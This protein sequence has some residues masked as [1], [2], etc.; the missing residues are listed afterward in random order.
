MSVIRESFGFMPDKT[1]IFKYILENSSGTQAHI[2]TLGATLQSFIIAD[3]NGEMKDVL[4][5]FDSV[6]DYLEKSNYQGATVGRYANRIG[7][8]SIDINGKNY[9]L[10]ANEKNVTSL[11]SAGDFSYS[12]W[13]AVVPDA[14]MVEMSYVS[15]DG[16]GGF[17]GEVSVKVIFRLTEDNK[18][19]IKYSGVSTK[20]TYMNFTNHAYFNLNGYDSGDILSH[21]LKIDSSFITPVDE[22]SIPLGGAMSVENTPFDFREFARIGERIASDHAQLKM[23]GGYDHNFCLPE[24]EGELREIAQSYSEDSGIKMAVLTTLPGVQFYAGNFLAGAEGKNGK[25]MNKRTGFCLET[26]FYPDTPHQPDFPSCL[27]KAGE[28]YVSETVYAF[29]LQK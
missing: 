28:E 17:P 25:A 15:P 11:H 20:D 18:L 1:E 29:S 2:L 19:S 26:Q 12:P 10:T 14:D 9:S 13:K 21:Y 27:F 22:L 24:S 5:G 8:A 23:T 6:S 16:E 4:L 7:G 3:K